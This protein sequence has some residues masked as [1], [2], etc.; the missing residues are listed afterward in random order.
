MSPLL[1]LILYATLALAVS[2]LCS[3]LEAGLLSLPRT[4]VEGM[5]ER[6]SRAGRYLQ[7]MKENID[8]PLVAILTLN[9][10]AH[11]I[12]A[13]GVGAQAGSI[14]GGPTNQNVAVGIAGAIM[15]FAILVLS[16]IIPKTLGAVYSRQLAVFIAITTRGMMILCAPFIWALEGINKMLHLQPHKKSI[17]RA[18]VLSTL[19]LGWKAGT[20]ADREHR[21]VSNMLGLSS[22][23]VEEVMTPRIVVT[24]LSHD[25]TVPEVFENH[26]PLHFSRIP[27]Y[28]DTGD[29]SKENLVGYISRFDLNKL[30][31][32]DPI[33]DVKVATL[34]KPLLKVSEETSVADL[35]ERL[36]RERRHIAMVIDE[37]GAMAGIVSLEDLLETLL[38]QEI[39]DESDIAVD[40]QELARSRT[41]RN[42]L[43]QRK[44]LESTPP[45]EASTEVP[46]EK[47]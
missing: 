16:E 21:I 11:T 41:A 39:V 29:G 7:K 18:E 12:G 10:V 30:M 27:I 45:P 43:R 36:L 47:K 42:G 40:M 15:T 44:E 28:D 23:P 20:L 35:L 1:L 46:P 8:R 37:F 17:S 26:W 38:G 5:V 4:H 19:R 31:R 9:T 14:W 22:V 32:E 25:L 6:G 2:F 34:A 33:P 24:S 3:I 13:A